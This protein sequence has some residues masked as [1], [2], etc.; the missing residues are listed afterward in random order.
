MKDFPLNSIF[1][2]FP[3]GALFTQTTPKL[4]SALPSCGDILEMQLYPSNRETLSYNIRNL[5]GVILKK[6]TTGFQH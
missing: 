3:F 4:S 1:S 5:F 2:V 6:S